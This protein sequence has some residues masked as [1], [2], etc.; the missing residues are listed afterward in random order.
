[1]NFVLRLIPPRPTFAADMT[2]AER[3]AMAAHVVYWR[4]RMDEG[5]VL[6][7]GPTQGPD[8]V[9]GIA[10]LDAAD[11][12]Q[13]R[14]LADADPLRADGAWSDELHPMLDAVVR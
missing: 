9:Y 10:I 6:I 5:R 2:P 4:E 3:E 1:M 13:A 12:A 14:A 8:C 11:E 7:F